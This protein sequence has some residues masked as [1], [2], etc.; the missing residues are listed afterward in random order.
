MLSIP[1]D[2]S[3]LE[4]LDVKLP[5]WIS[6]EPCLT[7]LLAMTL[8]VV[9]NLP[10][11]VNA[12]VLLFPCNVNVPLLFTVPSLDNVEVTVISFPSLLVKVPA[13]FNVFWLM[14]P[15]F[16]KFASS[17]SVPSL[18]VIVPAFSLADE[19]LNIALLSI[20][21]L[22]VISLTVTLPE[23]VNVLLLAIVKLF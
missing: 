23:V 12:P 16:V 8:S 20:V 2:T 18:P 6:N 17:L 15:L 3:K 11:P 19:I 21:P 22:L 5:L 14:V 1:F 13:L 4:A 10:L 9:I 7:V